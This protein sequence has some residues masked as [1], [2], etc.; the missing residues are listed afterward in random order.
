MRRLQILLAEDN[1]GDVLLVL[2]A[3]RVYGVEHVLHVVRDGSEAARYIDSMGWDRE[4][5]CPDVFLLDLNLPKRDGHEVLRL[6]RRR[7]DCE[8]R[9]VIVITSSDAERDRRLAAE[10]GA[11]RYF[12]KP[13]DLDE[14]IQLGALVAEV[15]GIYVGIE[16]SG[17]AGRH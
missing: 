14:F 4:S 2:E 15:A 1:H 3:L 11:T 8:S 5:P 10:A 12:R 9:P 13:S 6:F 7:S 17:G 16:E